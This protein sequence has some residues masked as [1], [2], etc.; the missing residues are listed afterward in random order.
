MRLRPVFLVLATTLIVL[1]ETTVPSSSFFLFDWLKPKSEEP[2]PETKPPENQKVL[3]PS[4]L[5][6][7]RG[8]PH[9]LVLRPN[10]ASAPDKTHSAL[11]IS[12][13]S[14][15]GDF[16][17]R[18]RVRTVEQLRE[19]SP[20]NPWEVAWVV[21]NYVDPTHFYYLA[22]K[23]IGWE[24]GKV[25]PAHKGAQRFM[26]TGETPY[27]I[28]EWHRFEIV[29]RDHGTTI[30]ING[31]K[32]TTILDEDGPYIGGRIGVYTE[33]AEIQL[34]N[35]TRPFTDDFSSYRKQKSRRDGVRFGPWIVPFLGYG[36]VS[37]V[38]LAN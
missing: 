25:D 11:L 15:F 31:Q 30:R 24:V 23:P 8:E 6:R 27:P 14:Y 3:K 37:I 2:P 18:G 36:E 32:V 1:A 5:R 28:G 12:Q 9:A 34:S 4:V 16:T 33:D 26:A 10:A 17:F 20:P 29:H 21:W 22:I 38:E 35:V 19:G 7:I 13:K